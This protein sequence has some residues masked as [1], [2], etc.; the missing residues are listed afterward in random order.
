MRQARR[1]GRPDSSGRR[2][3]GRVR[4]PTAHE[5]RNISRA[6]PAP[7]A[8]SASPC[9]TASTSSVRT[10]KLPQCRRHDA[11][12]D[13]EAG[14]ATE[15]ARIHEQRAPGRKPDEGGISLPDVEHD[16]A[17]LC[18]RRP[19][20]Q[21]G[22]EDQQRAASREEHGDAAHCPVPWDGPPHPDASRTRAQPARSSR[23]RRASSE[24]AG[25]RHVSHGTIVHECRRRDEPQR[26]LVRHPAGPVGKGRDRRRDS[27]RQPC[28]RSARST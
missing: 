15:A 2:R 16:D 6:A 22:G 9:V 19:G 26:S 3:A 28:R 18:G 1:R 27:P 4:L 25:T 5:D 23:A 24:G 20:R 14:R 11:F 13:V 21:R 8:W 17:E 10:P 7:P 12:A